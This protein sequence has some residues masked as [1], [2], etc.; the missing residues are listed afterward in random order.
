MLSGVE[1]NGQVHWFTDYAVRETAVVDDS[2][3]IE[4]AFQNGGIE[5]DCKL[6]VVVYKGG[7]WMI[8]VLWLLGYVGLVALAFFDAVLPQW[9]A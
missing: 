5:N 1:G 4:W 3:S 7:N 9:K 8:T 2:A 6:T